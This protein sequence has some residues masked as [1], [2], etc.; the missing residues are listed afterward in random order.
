MVDS[1]RFSLV[2]CSA[3]AFFEL[4]YQIDVH[5]HPIQPAY[6][7]VS[8]STRLHVS[9]P[10]CLLAFLRICLCLSFSILTNNE[11]SGS[12]PNSLSNLANLFYM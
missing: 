7:H 1:A 3:C 10:L 11:L 2:E 8:F 6:L 4:G 5:L 12:I 9:H